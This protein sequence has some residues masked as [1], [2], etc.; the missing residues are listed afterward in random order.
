MQR[1]LDAGR[2]VGPPHAQ[3]PGQAL[4]LWVRSLPNDL[5]PRIAQLTE[6]VEA[7]INQIDALEEQQAVEQGTRRNV[8]HVLARHDERGRATGYKIDGQRHFLDQ[9][10]ER[11]DELIEKQ[12]VRD[13]M[14]AKRG[15]TCLP[16][17]PLSARFRV[18][19]CCGW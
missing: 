17:P 8:R 10:T 2:R 12:V 15:G 16:G 6:Q 7:H 11:R 14:I 9:T 3:T 18:N 1:S 19:R 4:Q 5:A 13:S